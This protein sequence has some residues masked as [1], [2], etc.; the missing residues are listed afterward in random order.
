[1]TL[2]TTTSRR[3]LV[4]IYHSIAGLSDTSTGLLLLFAPAFTLRL[5]GVTESPN[6]LYFARYIGVFVL[7]VGATYLLIPAVRRGSPDSA[8][9]W[10][11][12]WAITA[13]IR[14]LVALFV[15]GQIALGIMESAWIA[16]VFTDAAFAGIQWIGLRNNWLPAQG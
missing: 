6:P 2:G 3:N 11:A 13:F 12:Q 5:M 1:M 4:L 15:L 7:S 8:I 14:S 9:W 10:R 16:V